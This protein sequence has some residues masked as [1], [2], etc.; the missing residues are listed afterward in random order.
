MILSRIPLVPPSRPA[1]YLAGIGAGRL[2]GTNGIL[3]RMTIRGFE[4]NNRTIDNLAGPF[5]ANLD[6]E[7][8]ERVEIVKGPNAIL[9]PTGATGGSLNVI[10]KSPMFKEQGSA[11]LMLG[12]FFAQKFMFD[13]TGPIPHNTHLAYRLIGSYQ[14][15]DTYVPGKLIQ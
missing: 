11:T 13:S 8:Y 14:N 7:L 9:S 10:T 5:Q 12:S 3:D 2:G 1:Q 4:S 15:T 6:P